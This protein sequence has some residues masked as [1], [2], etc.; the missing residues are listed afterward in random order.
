[1]RQKPISYTAIPISNSSRMKQPK[2]QLD[3]ISRRMQAEKARTGHLV[4]DER[5]EELKQLL[6][7]KLETV[8]EK[9]KQS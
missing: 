2:E 7:T 9:P 4:S 8:N 1:M 3:E 6:R 5:Y